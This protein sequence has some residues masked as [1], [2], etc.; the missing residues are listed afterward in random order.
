MRLATQQLVAIGQKRRLPEEEPKDAEH[1]PVIQGM[2]ARRQPT[3]EDEYFF[4]QERRR[5]LEEKVEA[6]EGYRLEARR[7]AETGDQPDS[8]WQRIARALARGAD[9][10]WRP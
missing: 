6:K 8:I 1:A 4:E 3:P 7:P 2:F 9:T 10:T 5:P